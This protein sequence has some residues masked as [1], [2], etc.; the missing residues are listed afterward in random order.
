MQQNDFKKAGILTLILTVV[1]VVGYELWLRDRGYSASFDDDERLWA[2]KRKEVYQPPSDAVVFIGSSRIK[3]DLDIPTWKQVTGTNAVQLSMVGSNPVPL[4][5]N[6]AEDENFKGRLVVDVTEVLF[7]NS[8]PPFFERPDKGINFYKKE[9]PS[10]KASFV[11]SHFLESNL[12]LLDKDYFAMNT[13]LRKLGLKNREGVNSKDPLPFPWE[14]DLTHFD[15]QSKMHDRFV[16]DTNLQNQVRMIWA[17]LGRALNVPPPTG[18]KLDSIFAGV[19]AD[20]DK[21]KSRGGQV[22]FVRTPSSGPFLVGESQGYPREKYWDRLLAV[23]DCP[24]VHFLDHK[25]MSNFQCPEFSHLTPADA[26]VYTK[27][28]AKRMEEK[29]WKFQGS[30]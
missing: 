8:L 30:N 25:S 12:V 13:Y 23:T 7:F 1:L 17:S 28:L 14:F 6:L 21:I 2:D 27:D 26:V 20:V 3:F 22:L 29:G 9:T 24:G 19:K 16:K 5:H 11:F 4:L 15:R 10:E 18:S